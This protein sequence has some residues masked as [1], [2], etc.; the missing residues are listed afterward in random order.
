MVTTFQANKVLT[1]IYSRKGD[2]KAFIGNPRIRKEP[3]S[4]PGGSESEK[5]V[6]GGQRA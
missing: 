2:G 1:G 5:R 3:E 6:A 4:E